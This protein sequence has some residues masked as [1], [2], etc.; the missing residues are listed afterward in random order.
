MGRNYV[1]VRIFKALKEK[2]KQYLDDEYPGNVI[3]WHKDS[4]FAVLDQEGVVIIIYRPVV[5]LHNK[6]MVNYDVKYVLPYYEEINYG[7][8]DN[9]LYLKVDKV[10]L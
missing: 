2:L 3:K 6:W 1:G 9:I 7:K 5:K 4:E 10:L 8:K